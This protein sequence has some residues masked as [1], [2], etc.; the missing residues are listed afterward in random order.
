MMRTTCSLLSAILFLAVMYSPVTAQMKPNPEKNVAPSGPWTI[1]SQDGSLAVAVEMK[2][3][4]LSY[5]VLHNKGEVLPS[6]P[7][8][9]TLKRLGQFTRHLQFTGQSTSMVNECY[10]MPVGKRS[11]CLN[12]ANELILDFLNDTGAKMSLIIRAYDDGIA[13]RYRIQGT[14][15]D[16]VLNEASSVRV[17][18]ALK[19][20]SPVIPSRIM[21]GTTMPM[22]GSQAL[23][24]TWPCQ[25]CSAW[26]LATGS[27]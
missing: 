25:P 19:G 24:M 15:E 20:G 16:T 4:R 2:E 14:G 9:L 12:R 18:Q 22:P 26:P 11:Q 1:S 23:I 8:G 6:A 13:Y 7:L 17:P 3:A 27:M 21:S 5:R 10:T